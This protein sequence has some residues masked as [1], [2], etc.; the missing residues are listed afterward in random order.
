MHKQCQHIKLVPT[1]VQSNHPTTTSTKMS[2]ELQ[3]GMLAP[4]IVVA[5]VKFAI[6]I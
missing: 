1:D 3:L 4:R 5:I 6:A 2:H